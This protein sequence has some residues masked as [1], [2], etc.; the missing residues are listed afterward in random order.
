MNNQRIEQFD[1]LR[2]I[3]AFIVIFHHCLISFPI[4]LD[5][6]YHE[7]TTNFFI[8][9]LSSTVFHVF[10][11]GH[12]SVILFFVLSGFVLS[13]PFLNG[14]HQPYKQYIIKRFTRIYLPYLT[15]ILF[16]VILYTLI[17]PISIIGLS[18]WF[19]GMWSN[20]ISFKLII[21][22]LLMIGSE[23]HNWNTVTWSL[24]HEMR[25]SIIFPIIIMLVLN[26][27]WRKVII[28]S[29][30]ITFLFAIT[31]F[32]ISRVIPIGSLGF[33]FRNFGETIH[34][35]LFFIFGAMLAKYR[36][37]LLKVYN[38]DKNSLFKIIILVLAL[39]LYTIEWTF[40]GIGYLKYSGS[41]FQQ[42]FMTMVLNVSISIGTSI[43]FVF[44]FA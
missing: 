23:T 11:S 26:F 17:K 27:N 7:K 29:V 36:L 30:L 42:F 21:S 38:K 14:N 4:F 20:P 10:W 31:F 22:H 24:V 15:S 1:S 41:D 16:S 28:F 12:E 32:N 33:L 6:Y 2:G 34:Y 43:L 19:N 37:T 5:A 40:D 13:L 9:F 8:N 18:E 39:I 3:A 25:I 35:S 44:V